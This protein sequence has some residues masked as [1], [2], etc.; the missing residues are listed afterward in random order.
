MVSQLGEFIPGLVEINLPLCQL[1]RKNDSWLWEPAQ[2]EAFHRIKD[3]LLEPHALVHYNTSKS[4]VFRA[5]AFKSG[6]GAVM[7]QVQTT[8]IDDH[9]ASHQDH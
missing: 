7:L 4:T 9:C 6:I 3:T 5:D 1:F 2:E 8:E